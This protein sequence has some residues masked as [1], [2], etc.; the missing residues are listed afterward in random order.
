MEQYHEAR[1]NWGYAATLYIYI[2]SVTAM[3]FLR[4]IFIWKQ[5]YLL[6]IDF[7]LEDIVQRVI[8]FK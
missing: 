2:L 4:I 3:T 5:I 8:F 6:Y 7:Y 1:Y